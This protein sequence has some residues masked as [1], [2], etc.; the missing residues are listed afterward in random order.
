MRSGGSERDKMNLTSAQNAF[1]PGYP[2]HPK[3][4]GS[5]ILA[6]QKYKTFSVAFQY[7]L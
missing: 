2:I 4:P 1:N 6:I 5:D 3:H 7:N